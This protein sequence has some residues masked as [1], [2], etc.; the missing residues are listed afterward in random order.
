MQVASLKDMIGKK[1][2]EIE[3]LQ[4]GKDPG[5]TNENLGALTITP[6]S[7]GKSSVGGS[8]QPVLSDDEAEGSSEVLE[9][10]DEEREEKFG[11]SSPV[12]PVRRVAAL[13]K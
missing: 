9:D 6:P 11:D 10:I 12:S 8:P 1:D 2:E 7:P 5:V 4:L 3:R 13:T